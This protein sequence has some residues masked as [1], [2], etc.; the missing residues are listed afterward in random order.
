MTA[1]HLGNPNSLLLLILPG[2]E[3]DAKALRT[4]VQEHRSDL[5]LKEQAIS[6]EE[7]KQGIIRKME[8]NIIGVMTWIEPKAREVALS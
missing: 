1:L 4:L 8:E 3:D 6:T 2:E 7:E 5:Q